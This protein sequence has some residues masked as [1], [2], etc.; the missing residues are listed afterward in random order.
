MLRSEDARNHLTLVVEDFANQT[1]FLPKKAF[2]IWSAEYATACDLGLERLKARLETILDATGSIEGQMA[3]RLV[4]AM[5][6][7]SAPKQAPGAFLGV[8]VEVKQQEEK[9]E[10]KRGF[11]GRLRR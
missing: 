7:E 2:L 5:G 11:F 8:G 1:G 3:D 4:E 6:G 10:P 9:E